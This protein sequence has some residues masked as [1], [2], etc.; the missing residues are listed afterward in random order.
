MVG[1]GK[2]RFS[3]AVDSVGFAISHQGFC[4]GLEVILFFEKINERNK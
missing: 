2:S 1:E 4:L 3:V